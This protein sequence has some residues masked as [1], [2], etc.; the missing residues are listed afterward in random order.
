MKKMSSYLKGNL[1]PRLYNEDNAINNCLKGFALGWDKE[2]NEIYLSC[3]Q[4]G[5]KP[6]IGGIRFEDYTI[7]YNELLNRFTGFYDIYTCK[8]INTENKLLSVPSF[9][10]VQ[11]NPVVDRNQLWLHNKGPRGSF[12]DKVYPSILNYITT[13]QG[14]VGTFTNLLYLSEVY[15]INDN[16]L[17]EKIGRAHV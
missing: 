1:S 9:K 7:V 17:Q 3:K 2:F 10:L 8:Y 14:T 12:Y 13:A 16:D 6:P 4:S 5:C 15:E 11:I